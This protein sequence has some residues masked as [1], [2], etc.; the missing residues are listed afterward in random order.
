LIV[1]GIDIG[2]SGAVAAMDSRSYQVHDLP[3]SIDGVKRLDGRLLINLLRQFIGPGEPFA[4]IYEDISVRPSAGRL[5]SHKTE[6]ALSRA[7]G[8]LEGVLDIMR[9]E[10]R[11][12]VSPKAWQKFYGLP[13]G[14]QGK[15]ESLRIARELYPMQAHMLTRQADHGRSDSLLMAGYY[16]A[17]LA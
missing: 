10:E 9:C 5:M 11:H 15:A 8:C 7:R 2:M 13:G 16:M 6:A 3:I 4:C 14:K 1:L 12:H 17:K